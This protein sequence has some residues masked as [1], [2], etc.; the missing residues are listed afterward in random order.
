MLGVEDF[1]AGSCYQSLRPVLSLPQR[2]QG[3]KSAS[4]NH[5][6]ATKAA[7]KSIQ[8][9]FSKTE[10]EFSVAASPN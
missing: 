8:P 10:L 4:Y 3:M 2:I 7:A 5:T 1:E 6:S 9:I